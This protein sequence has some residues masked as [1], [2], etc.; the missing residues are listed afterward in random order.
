MVLTIE[1][2]YKLSYDKFFEIVPTH[3]KFFFKNFVLP[4]SIS[5]K[6]LE[7]LNRKN[8]GLPEDDLSYFSFENSQL[9]SVSLCGQRINKP[10]CLSFL[11]NQ[12]LE[13]VEMTNFRNFPLNSWFDFLNVEKLNKLD[14]SNSFINLNKRENIFSRVLNLRI[15]DVSGTN[16]NNGIFY[17]IC[18]NLNY[19]EELNISWTLV[20]KFDNISKLTNLKS[21]INV[22]PSFPLLELSNLKDNENL[23]KL[24][25]NVSTGILDEIDIIELVQN[26]TW[27]NLKILIMSNLNHQSFPIIK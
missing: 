3:Y 26:F 7:Y 25:V 27:K 18:N 17:F 14:F 1:S 11:K 24:D 20:K 6:I 15:L 22:Y 10:E 4:F 16:L 9:T 2:L 19:L 23:E 5:N 8:I 21:F 13:Y 12:P